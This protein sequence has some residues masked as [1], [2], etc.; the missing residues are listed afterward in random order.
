MD[1]YE[2]KLVSQNSSLLGTGEERQA[3]P[4]CVYTDFH[5]KDTIFPVI[6]S[7]YICIYYSML[8][9]D[10]YCV[11]PMSIYNSMHLYSPIKA[12]AYCVRPTFFIHMSYLFYFV[13]IF[14]TLY[15]IGFL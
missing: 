10:A 6:D 4:I 1:T 2:N 14:M 9:A 11:M 5:D 15:V 13:T 8:E 3:L 12:D 7:M